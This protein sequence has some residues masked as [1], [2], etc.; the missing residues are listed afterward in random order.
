[1][2]GNAMTNADAGQKEYEISL[3]LKEE[4]GSAAVK[5]LMALHGCTI[6][7]DNEPRRITL[8]YPI[9]K[10]PSALFGFMRFL[11]EPQ[12]LKELSKALEFEPSCLRFL[13]I[14]ESFEKKA[15]RAPGLRKAAPVRGERIQESAPRTPDIVTNE[16][17]ERKLEEILK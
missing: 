5:N 1:M 12:S 17:L 8:A 4:S 9:K 7:L 3:L 15:E 13:V 14:S 11:A 6:T 2:V 10:E 16:E